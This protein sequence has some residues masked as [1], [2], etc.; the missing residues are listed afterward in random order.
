MKNLRARCKFP[1]FRT[2]DVRIDA[3]AS[4]L[5]S[6]TQ[7]AAICQAAA[8]AAMHQVSHT[9]PSFYITLHAF[10]LSS[11]KAGRRSS[12]DGRKICGSRL[13]FLLDQDWIATLPEFPIIDWSSLWHQSINGTSP[14]TSVESGTSWTEGA[15]Y[16]ITFPATQAEFLLCLTDPSHWSNPFQEC[17]QLT[18]ETSRATRS[19]WNF[20]LRGCE[21]T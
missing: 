13:D 14:A 1:Y 4:R 8:D 15:H 21:I 6:A 20:A 5:F 17:R 7:D 10:S 9:L 19:V 3:K 12:F 18:N 11:V 16:E 2:F